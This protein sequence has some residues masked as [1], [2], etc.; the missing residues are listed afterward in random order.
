MNN[1]TKAL[2]VLCALTLLAP[3]SASA[4]EAAP[5]QT[6]TFRDNAIARTYPHCGDMDLCATITYMN[7]DVLSLYSEGAA[8]GQP[9][10]LHCV[11]TSGT[12]TVY[13]FSRVAD[14]GRFGA[15]LTM[16]HGYVYLDVNANNDGTINLAFSASPKT[17]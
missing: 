5:S 6:A 2:G 13:E 8:A 11:M 16:D 1:I 9:Y 4:Q 15:R 17:P 14:W 12:R 3:P 10:T 7:G